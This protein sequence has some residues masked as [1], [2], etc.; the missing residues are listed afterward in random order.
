MGEDFDWFF[1]EEIIDIFD[2]TE[3]EGK[4]LRMITFNW[5]WDVNYVDFIEVVEEVV[6]AKI[7]MDE[8]TFLVE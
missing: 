8:L 5:L 6:L 3:E 1:I 7:G 4:G 2:I